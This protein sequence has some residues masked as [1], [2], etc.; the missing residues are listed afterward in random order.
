MPPDLLEEFDK[1]LKEKFI[2]KSL[3]LE[4]LI[5]GVVRKN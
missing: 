1:K 4:G 3:L 2:D 5:K